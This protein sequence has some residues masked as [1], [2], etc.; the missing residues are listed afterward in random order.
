MLVGAGGG[1]VNADFPD[2]LAHRVRAGLRVRKNEVPGAAH[3]W[4]TAGLLTS[5]SARSAPVRSFHKMPLMTVRW[6]RH[7]PPR[8]CRL[9]GNSGAITRSIYAHVLPSMQRDAAAVTDRLLG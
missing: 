4:Y 3:S 8:R 9:E 6:S 5:A 2:D 1:A 7:W